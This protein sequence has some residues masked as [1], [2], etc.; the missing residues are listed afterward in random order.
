[1]NVLQTI[2]ITGLKQPLPLPQ[3][4]MHRVKGYNKQK[5][6][7]LLHKNWVLV[8]NAPVTQNTLVHNGDELKILSPYTQHAKIFAENIPLDIVDETPNYI[9]INKPSGMACHGGL[10][11]YWGTLLNALAYHYQ[12]TG[13]TV[14]LQNGLVHRLDKHTS[15]LMVVAKTI[16][17][18]EMLLPQFKDKIAQRKYT[19]LV[20]GIVETNEGTINIPIGRNPSNHLDI[21]AYPDSSHGKEAI[22][23]YS[24][25]ARYNN[26]T[27]L[28]CVLETGRTNQI[29]IHLQYIG[30][31]IVGDKRYPP[32]DAEVTANRLMLHAH[33]LSFN[34]LANNLLEYTCPAPFI[35]K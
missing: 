16:A 15:G 12:A 3:Y 9:V 28:Q 29:R 5:V 20:H 34:S 11:S 13:Q 23:H 1:M 30:H 8:N 25:V 14:E 33:Y 10:G 31:S 7:L 4:I 24:V 2:N 6:E 26:T 22:T 19:A 32:V 21:R 27:Q 17:G 18:R 35:E